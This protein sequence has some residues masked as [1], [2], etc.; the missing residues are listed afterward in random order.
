MNKSESSPANEWNVNPSE[1]DYDPA[2]YGNALREWTE[3][4]SNP[5]PSVANRGGQ[6][7]LQDRA[8]RLFLESVA[9]TSQIARE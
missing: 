4:S 3:R 9:C 8:T 6:G 2:G 1:V 7:R 5:L